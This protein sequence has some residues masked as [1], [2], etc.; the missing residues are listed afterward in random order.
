MK[1]L[2]SWLKATGVRTI[3]TMAQTAAGL[4]GASM[5]LGEVSWGKVL[6]ATALAGVA[7]ILMAI[8]GLPE[9]EETKEEK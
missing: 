7:C 9:L 4:I 5:F 3:R 8:A 6:S 2:K 1:G